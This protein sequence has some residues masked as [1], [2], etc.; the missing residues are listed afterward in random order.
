MRTWF[1]IPARKGSKRFPF[2]N[3][4]LVPICLSKLKNEWIQKTIISTNDSAITEIAK[5]LVQFYT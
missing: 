2:K 4:K 3:R 1:I 5:N